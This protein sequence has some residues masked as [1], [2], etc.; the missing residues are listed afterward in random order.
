M[1]TSRLRFLPTPFLLT[2]ALLLPGLAAAQT[3]PAPSTQS[4]PGSALWTQATLQAA[5]YVVLPA[6]LEGNAKLLNADQQKIILDAMQRDSQNALHRKYPAA[7]FAGDPNLPGVIVVHP[8]WTVPASLLPW[9]SF[10]ARLEL[11][12]GGNRAVVADSFGVLD[13][14]QHQAD[15]ANYVFDRVAKKLP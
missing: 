4:V 15:A 3:P 12:Q 14:W 2:A 7:S 13:V 11:N 8:V 10:Q 5:T 1:K 9:N 6:T